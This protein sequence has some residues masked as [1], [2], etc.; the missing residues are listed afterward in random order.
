MLLV[1][2]IVTLI[3]FINI[4]EYYDKNI[5]LLS[6]IFQFIAII[7]VIK[8]NNYILQFIDKFFF[9]ILLSGFFYFENLYSNYFAIILLLITLI[10]RYFCD[11]CLFYFNN[12]NYFLNITLNSDQEIKYNYFINAVYSLLLV[13]YLQ[14]MLYI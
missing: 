2:F 13:L 8:N 1:S 3:L 10:T 5:L 6:N 4:E 9:I 7:C 14:K 12:E 11:C